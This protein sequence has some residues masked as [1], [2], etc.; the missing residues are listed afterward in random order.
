[1]YVIK[2]SGGPNSLSSIVVLLSPLFLG[3]LECTEKLTKDYP[4]RYH[5][6]LFSLGALQG[7]SHCQF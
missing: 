6:F 1:M 2:A 3:P 4:H 7:L 5:L